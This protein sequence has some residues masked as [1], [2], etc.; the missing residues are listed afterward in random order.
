MGEINVPREE[1]DALI[2]IDADMLDD[3]IE[4]CMDEKRIGPLRILRIESC[5]QYAASKLRAFES[6][7]AEYGMARAAK[8]HAETECRARRAGRD[9]AH[10]VQ[11][12]KH[13]VETE[14]QEGLFFYVDDQIMPPQNFSNRLTVRVSYRWRLTIEG[15]WVSNSIT[16]SH[17][18]VLEPDYTMPLRKRKP[19]AGKQEQHRQDELYQE[20]ERLVRMGLHSVR[21]YF[22]AGGNGATIPQTFE[23]KAD[24]YTRRLNNFSGQFWLMQSLAVE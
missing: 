21:E 23:A 7:L 16:F 4:K 13:R 17:E 19:S 3:L 11:Q 5:G 9:L 8:K 6:A 2:A 14:K 18:A 15:Q 10:A 24:P 12:M 1:Q 22:R 20:W